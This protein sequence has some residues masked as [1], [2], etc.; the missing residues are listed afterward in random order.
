M[1]YDDL[2]FEQKLV[3]GVQQIIL[4]NLADGS[5]LMPDYSTRFKI[6]ADFV[7][8]IW[9][10]MD[11]DRLRQQI[12]ERIESELAERIV[13]QMAA[14]LATDIKQILS[15]KERREA[16]RAIARAHME[17]IMSLGVK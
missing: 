10:G 6:P 2:S 17:S 11:K 9:A 3:Q 7:A 5:F 16:L 15:V 8:S 12:T 13:N 4:K 1:K 14:E